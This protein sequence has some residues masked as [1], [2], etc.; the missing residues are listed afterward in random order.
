MWERA[1][2]IYG[3][4]LGGWLMFSRRERT[5]GKMFQLE[6]RVSTKALSWSLGGAEDQTVRW[7]WGAVDR[8]PYRQQEGPWQGGLE[9]LLLGRKAR[10]NSKAAVGYS[11]SGV[12]RRPESL[13]R[14]HLLSWSPCRPVPASAAMFGLLRVLCWLCFSTT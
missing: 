2:W 9:C 7:G 14:E 4:T 10:G 12:R 3:G 8:G 13:P 5:W 1:L 11:C 6:G